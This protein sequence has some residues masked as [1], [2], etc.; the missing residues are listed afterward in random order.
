VPSIEYGN[1]FRQT[2]GGK[3]QIYV[4]SH[5][6]AGRA[7]S[8]E[9]ATMVEAS[10]RQLRNGVAAGRQRVM[11]TGIRTC[12][13]QSH[14]DGLAVEVTL[15]SEFTFGGKA[16]VRQEASTAP[17]GILKPSDCP[18]KG[19]GNPLSHMSV[20]FPLHAILLEG[21]NRSRGWSFPY[22]AHIIL[23][24]IL[25]IPFRVCRPSILWP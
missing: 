7:M 5:E 2:S 16:P 11:A 24:C 14:Y 17:A 20:K 25:R 9:L 23:I 13:A 19:H 18:A 12:P 1:D 3:E 21:Q 15:W 10:R 22:P 4:R 8:L 6:E